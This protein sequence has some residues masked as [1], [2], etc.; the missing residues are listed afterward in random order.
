MVGNE[1]IVLRRLCKIGP[2]YEVIKTGSRGR[3]SNEAAIVGTLALFK[4]YAINCSHGQ[5]ATSL[6]PRPSHT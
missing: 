6:L 2:W 1:V 5:V 4:D 3:S